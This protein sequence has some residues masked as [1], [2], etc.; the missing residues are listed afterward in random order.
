M[1]HY[2]F[3]GESLHRIVGAI[4][5]L[6]GIVAITLGGSVAAGFADESSDLDLHVYA[7]EPLADSQT[8]SQRLMAIADPGTDVREERSWGLEDHFWMGGRLVELVYVDLDDLLREVDHAYE[9]GLDGEG[10][11]TARLYYAA[12]GRLLHDPTGEFASLRDRLTAY[13]EPTRRRLLRSNPDLLRAYLKQLRTAHRR[14]DLL[15]VLHRRY[16]VQMVFFNLLFAINRR[17]HPGEKRLLRHAERCELQPPD[18]AAR[19]STIARLPADDP[20]LPDA[21]ESLSRDLIGL[22]VAER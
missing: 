3:S 14:G 13:P 15:F 18:M 20:A 2:H 17:Y 5:D 16:S 6:A 9:S 4:G 1:S 7:R 12:E 10:F 21:L 22:A 19:W 11:V 8:R